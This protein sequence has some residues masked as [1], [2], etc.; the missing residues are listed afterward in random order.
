MENNITNASE[1]S[2]GSV[3]SSTYAT[4]LRNPGVF[5]G[6]CFIALIPMIATDII[7]HLYPSNTRG[8]FTAGFGIINML[9]QGAI[10]YAVYQSLRGNTVTISE[11]VS[12]CTP[13][14]GSLIG[15]SILTFFGIALG[16]LL[17][18]IPGII[19]MCK[20]AV[21]VQTCVVENL[22]AQESLK[23]SSELTKDY[24][25]KIFFLSLI[26]LVSNL[27]VLFLSNFIGILLF[28]KQEIIVIF[29]SNFIFLIP[30]TF[31]DVMTAV[32]YYRLRE[33]K[34]GTAIDNLANVFD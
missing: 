28:P 19:L 22:G 33:A 5:F 23:R 26:G 29:L 8:G 18:V 9:V 13:K 3:L 17:L 30:Y 15:V 10:S 2:I 4:L 14:L 20:W 6:I 24:R 7:Q 31:W 1:F 27:F 32:I 16:F 34:E 25:V 12:R 11:S 21:T